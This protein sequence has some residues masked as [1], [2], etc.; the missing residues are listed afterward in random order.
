M[1]EGHQSFA[2]VWCVEF[3]E[4][5][6]RI[7]RYAKGGKNCKVPVCRLPSLKTMFWFV[8]GVHAA[9]VYTYVDMR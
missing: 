1:S 3:V 6:G 9:C 7:N 2:V 5:T 4:G 8:L